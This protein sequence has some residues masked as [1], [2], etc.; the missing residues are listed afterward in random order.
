VILNYQNTLPL[1]GKITL[2]PDISGCIN[3]GNVNGI[4]ALK[5]DYNKK[6]GCGL[7]YNTKNSCGFLIS[8]IVKRRVKIGYYYNLLSLDHQTFGSHCLNIGLI[9]K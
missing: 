8:G 9:L 4:I 1:S 6:I 2:S 3:P 7:L 5:V